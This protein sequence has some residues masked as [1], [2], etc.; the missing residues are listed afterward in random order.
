MIAGTPKRAALALA[1]ALTV[2][3]PRWV[4]GADASPTT[5][6]VQLVR[7]NNETVPPAPGD[8]RVGIKV[9]LEL[10]GIYRWRSYWE[11]ARQEVT[12]PATGKTL[13][14]L[15]KDRAVEIDLTTPGKRKVTAFE[16]D[17]EVAITTRPVGTAWTVIGGER[18][19]KTSW[20]IVVRRDK[21]ADE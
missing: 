14:R 1:I 6:Y 18:D 8:K 4:L 7:G 19:R 16:N 17:K 10:H 2:L 21:P 11:I 3:V 5:F 12:L 9:S 15:N 20:F 13:V